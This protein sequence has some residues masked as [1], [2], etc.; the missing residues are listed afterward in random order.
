MFSI[1][2]LVALGVVL[3]PCFSTEMNVTRSLQDTFS[4]NNCTSCAK[5]NQ[6]TCLEEGVCQCPTV[7][8]TFFIYKHR[9]ESPSSLI[10]GECTEIRV[11]PHLNQLLL[12]CFKACIFTFRTRARRESAHCLLQCKKKSWNICNKIKTGFW[13]PRETYSRLFFSLNL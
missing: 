6:A 11:V 4:V 12:L 13:M 2:F 9:C 1:A 8:S 10:N 5:F 7:E 3:R